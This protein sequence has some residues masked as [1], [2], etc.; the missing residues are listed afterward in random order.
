[1]PKVRIAEPTNNFCLNPD[2]SAAGIVSIVLLSTKVK[3]R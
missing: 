2:T 1:M 3:S